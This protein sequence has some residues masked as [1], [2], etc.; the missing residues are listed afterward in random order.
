MLN[1]F[2]EVNLHPTNE[3]IQ[4]SARLTLF[5]LTSISLIYLILH[6]TEGSFTRSIPVSVGF[7]IAGIFLY[8]T[9][10]MGESIAKPFYIMTSLIVWL[11]KS[12]LLAIFYFIL[13]FPTSLIL[14][15]VT[16]IDPLT[17]KK[18][19]NKKSWWTGP[20]RQKA[21]GKNSGR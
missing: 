13:L 5:A 11:T 3:E 6:L 17:L 18:D 8:I 7:F 19:S 9:S 16:T 21:T 10:K 2:K 15:A 12:L 4:S 1:P 20:H 14:R